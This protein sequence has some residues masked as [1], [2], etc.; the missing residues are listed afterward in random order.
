MNFFCTKKH[1]DEWRMTASQNNK[2][3]FALNMEEALV[4]AEAVFGK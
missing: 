4:V 3:V 1:L 2:D